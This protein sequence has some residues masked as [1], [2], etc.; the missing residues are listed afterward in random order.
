MNSNTPAPTALSASPSPPVFDR[1]DERD[2]LRHDATLF[3]EDAR[4][5]LLI[6]P[7]WVIVVEAVTPEEFPHAHG[8]ASW[9]Y[10]P[11]ANYRLKLRTDLSGEELRW[12]IYH[13]LLEMIFARYG[14][15]CIEQIESRGDLE[16]CFATYLHEQHGDIRNEV[17]EWLLQVIL[18]IPRP[19][20][21]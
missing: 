20:T 11:N 15:F 8:S 4:R 9:T 12:T 6:P 2:A 21:P 14:E 3:L 19:F 10:L 13:E 5:R 7:R 1:T 17:V 16:G 18:G